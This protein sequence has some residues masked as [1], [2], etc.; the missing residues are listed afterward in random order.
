MRTQFTNNGYYLI[1]AI[2]IAINEM[3]NKTAFQVR[4]EDNILDLE[5]L[6]PG[7]NHFAYQFFTSAKIVVAHT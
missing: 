4:R 6:L 2:S 5:S 1:A 7:H 3:G